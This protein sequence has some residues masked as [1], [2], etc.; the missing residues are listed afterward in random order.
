MRVWLLCLFVAAAAMNN[1]KCE[2]KKA[3][4]AVED[5]MGFSRG[6]DMTGEGQ[7]EKPPYTLVS[8]TEEAVAGRSRITAVVEV[9]PGLDHASV[10]QVL[11]DA[12]HDRQLQRG[13]SVI[14]VIA[15]P[16]KLRRLATPLGECVFARDGNG[17]EGTKVGFEEIR[18]KLP[19]REKMN[20]LGLSP[21]SEDEYLRV[22]GVENLLGRGRSRNEAVHTTAAH[23]EVHVQQVIMALEKAEKLW[24]VS[25]E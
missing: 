22:L 5:F 8:R 19:T 20:A 25:A 1:C 11:R 13:A 14:K 9:D 10:N 3:K 12:C 21:M 17:W 4:K 6:E 16:G 7:D 2:A 24:G 15:W 23:H 18:V